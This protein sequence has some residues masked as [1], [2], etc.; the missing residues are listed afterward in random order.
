MVDDVVEYLWWKGG[1]HRGSRQSDDSD[2]AP[3]AASFQF[4][5]CLHQQR[6]NPSLTVFLLDPGHISAPVPLYPQSE[7]GH[8]CTELD[9]LSRI[10]M[11]RHRL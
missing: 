6:R 5:T 4:H 8:L 7:C 10:L 3:A 2:G 1:R 11:Q 9:V